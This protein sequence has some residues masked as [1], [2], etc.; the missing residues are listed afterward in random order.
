M[1]NLKNTLVY[2]QY[3]KLSCVIKIYLFTT[4]FRPKILSVLPLSLYFLT[5][6]LLMSL[7]TL[8]ECVF[9]SFWGDWETPTWVTP[10]KQEPLRF[11]RCIDCI[12]WIT[13]THSVSQQQT[14]PSLTRFNRYTVE[15]WF[16]LTYILIWHNCMLCRVCKL[17]TLVWCPIV[18][19]SR[20]SQSQWIENLGPSTEK[21]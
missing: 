3:I 15:S 20:W 10:Y 17:T 12:G 14:D 16:K 11:G 6:P 8:V 5:L 19:C 7:P 21:V 4:K 1:F 9:R 13:A 18:S 2:H